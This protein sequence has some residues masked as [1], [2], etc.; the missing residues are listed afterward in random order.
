M[1]KY[2]GDF[3]QH[4]YEAGF[5]EA[6]SRFIEGAKETNGKKFGLSAKAKFNYS[7]ALSS[8]VR[9]GDLGAIVYGG[10]G[11]FKALLDS[12]MSVEEARRKFEF[13]TLRSQQS[14]N[15][16]SISDWQQQRGIARLY[17]AFKNTSLQYTPRGSRGLF[18]CLLKF[19]R[20]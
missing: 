4:R 1:M 18:I 8:F 17:L 12:G 14:G 10:Y 11:Q 5:N 16:A 2:N 20:F 9:I 15:A 19:I 7:N 13:S 6:M 3:L